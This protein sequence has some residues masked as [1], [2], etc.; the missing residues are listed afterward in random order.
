MKRLSRQLLGKSQEAFLL[1]LE[2]YNKP[3][4]QYRLES[5]CFF[6]PNAWELMLKAYLLGK[7][8]EYVGIYQRIEKADSGSWAV[9][10]AGTTSGAKLSDWLKS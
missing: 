8:N 7:G 1:S 4:I 5:F 3:T 2:I 9:F 6:F 10:P